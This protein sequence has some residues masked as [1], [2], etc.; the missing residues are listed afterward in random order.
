MAATRR[1]I[2]T[3]HSNFWVS[4]SFQVRSRLVNHWAVFWCME[5]IQIYSRLNTYKMLLKSIVVWTIKFLEFNRV[6]LEPDF[7]HPQN[8]FFFILLEKTADIGQ[9]IVMVKLFYTKI[10]V[11]NRHQERLNVKQWPLHNPAAPKL[12][13]YWGNS[14]FHSVMTDP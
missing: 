6:M 7:C 10:C 11:S 9:H 13:D 3:T 5:F 8:N 14:R 12:H 2:D 1:W 4:I